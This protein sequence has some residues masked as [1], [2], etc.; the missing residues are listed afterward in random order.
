[1]TFY[2]RMMKLLDQGVTASKEFAM[3]AGA[4]AQD[5]GERGVRMVEIKQL[6]GKAQKLLGRLG[7]EVYQAFT[8][9]NQD[10][11][12][13]SAPEIDILMQELAKVQSSIEEKENELK[14]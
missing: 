7:N 12:S 2:D 14:K 9:R 10:N 3:K 8:E 4:K 1:M 11:V 13:R 6:E 5:L